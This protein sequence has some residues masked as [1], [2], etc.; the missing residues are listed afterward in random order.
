MRLNGFQRI[1]FVF[2][3]LIAICLSGCTDNNS[4]SLNI[5]PAINSTKGS[6]LESSNSAE[7]S[8]PSYDLNVGFVFS[9][10]VNDET[11][12]TGQINSQRIAAYNSKSCEGLGTCYVDNVNAENFENAINELKSDN[13]KDIYLFVSDCDDVLEK[14]SKDNP[15][16]NFIYHGTH[17]ITSNI[18]TF[19]GKVQQGG[20]IAGI[21]ASYNSETH[22]IGFIGDESLVDN[23]IVANSIQ[24]GSQVA[25]SDCQVFFENA[26]SNNAIELKIDSLL[27]ENCDV[28]VCY[29]ETS[30]S[31]EYCQ[32]KGVKFIGS[33]DFSEKLEQFPDMLM[34]FYCDYAPYFLYDFKIMQ[35]NDRCL[36]ADFV[37]TI[38]DSTIFVSDSLPKS[39]EDS[40]KLMDKIVSSFSSDGTQILDDQGFYRFE[41]TV[42]SDGEIDLEL[43]S[44]KKAEIRKYIQAQYDW[45]DAQ[46]GRNTEDSYIFEIWYNAEEKYGLLDGEAKE[47]DDLYESR[48]KEEEELFITS[49]KGVHDGDYFIVSGE[50]ENNSSSTVKFVVVK[51]ELID[52][53]G[54]VF[55]SDTTFAV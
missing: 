51:I 4:T 39:K 10:S 34:Y 1:G 11:S 35:E 43:T 54:K 23:N 15:D 14:Y 31:E 40:Q 7:Q 13:C 50:V 3:I 37:G 33:H 27:E 12:F 46:E 42:T 53:N 32:Q 36:P 45:Y 24:T 38:K 30:Y 21:M 28:I 25:G 2:I 17:D 47:L 5:K 26:Q 19:S 8:L 48:K 6:T 49:L 52:E 44:E 29:T 16:V 55:D 41:N 20:Y 9:G 18:S 22:N